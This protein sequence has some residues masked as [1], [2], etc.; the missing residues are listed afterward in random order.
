MKNGIR[1][2]KL[3]PRVNVCIVYIVLYLFGRKICPAN[4]IYRKKGH[5]YALV[6]SRL[7]DVILPMTSFLVTVGLRA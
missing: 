6:V 7:G 5:R 3:D 2:F 1:R 4:G